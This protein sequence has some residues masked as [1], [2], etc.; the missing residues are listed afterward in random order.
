MKHGLG[1]FILLIA[2]FMSGCNKVSVTEN[3]P[4]KIVNIAKY[5]LVYTPGQAV[6]ETLLT[7]KLLGDNIRSVRGE[8][9][10]VEMS[11]GTIPLFFQ[12]DGQGHFAAQ[13]LLGI[14]SE[15]DMFWQVRLTITDNEGK[16]HQVTDQFQVQ[17]P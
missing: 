11:M 12:K 5:Q 9:V 15:P 8:I 7:L 10:G 4:E 16:V 17:Y 3:A 1:V 6:P 14:C 2:L 13:Y